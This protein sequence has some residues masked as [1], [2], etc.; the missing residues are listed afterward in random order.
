MENADNVFM[1]GLSFQETLFYVFQTHI[2]FEKFLLA[3]KK[4][5]PLSS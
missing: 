1:K 4:F 2:L 5:I 3:K